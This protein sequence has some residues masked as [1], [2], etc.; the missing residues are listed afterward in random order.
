[1]TLF[2]QS[3]ADL[4]AIKS[5]RNPNNYNIVFWGDS[6]VQRNIGSD[7]RFVSNNIFEVAMQRA[8]DFNPLLFAYGGDGAFTGTEDNLNFLVE[9]IKSLNKDKN[10]DSVPFFMVPGNHD[11]ARLGT[12]LS[13]DNYKKIIAPEDIHWSIDLP[14]FRLRL[15]GLNSLYHYIYKEYGLTENELEFLDNSLPDIRCSRNVF[16]TM[17]VPPRE[18]ELDWVGDDAFPN[19]RGRKDFYKIVKNKVSKVLIGH[20]HDFQMAKAHG[21]RFILSGGG[22][23]TLN[24]GARFHIVVINIR[25]YGKYNIITPKF[26]PVGWNRA[27]EPVSP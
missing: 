20:I 21:V 24:V 1:M 27:T 15:V 19:G 3:F 12:T 13:L 16:V 7:V 23:A 6:W 26:V 25:I 10:G 18:P 5:K 22:G 2:D 17:H 14:E 4:Q 11:S 8:M 9:K